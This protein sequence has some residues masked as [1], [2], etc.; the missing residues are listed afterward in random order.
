MAKKFFNIIATGNT[1]TIFLYGDIGDYYYDGVRSADIVR[2]LKEAE[3][4]YKKIDVRINSNGGDVYAGIAIFN[5]FRNSK[6]DINIYV[7]GIAASM[8]SVIALC[9]KPVQMSQYARLMLHSVS[10]GGYGTKNDLKEV[11]EQIESLE[12]TLCEM[13]AKKTGMTAETIKST[14]F[15]EKDHYLTADEALSLGFIDGIYD[16]DPV[17]ED[18]TPEQ[19]YQIFNNRLSKPQNKSKMN[20]DELKKRPRFKDCATDDDVLRILGQLET[21][22]GKVP[23]LTTEVQRLTGELKVFQDKA[24]AEETAAKKKLLDDAIADGR[25]NETQR[26]AYQAILD[27]D[28][29]NGTTVLNSLQPKKRIVNHLDDRKGEPGAWAKRQEE[30]ADKLNKK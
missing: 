18:S 27:K 2:E 5:A 1:A 9:G 25:I 29:E 22:S 14:Y 26:P 19:I 30:I 21:E 4:A 15:D 20:I 8:A 23:G 28:L 10:G 13:Y 16:A 17:P 3:A 24:V 12:G 7:D 11:I 6:S